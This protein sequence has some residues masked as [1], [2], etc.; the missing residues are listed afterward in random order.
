MTKKTCSDK[1]LMTVKFY[2]TLASS[3]LQMSVN[4]NILSQSVV[5]PYFL[6][7]NIGFQLTLQMSVNVKI[8][9][10]SV[11]L[12]YFLVCNIGFQLTLQMS[13]NVKILSQCCFTIFPS[14]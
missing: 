1:S 12:P 4:V 7:C 14:L 8:L 2:V 11:V 6:V 13:V 10:Q 3:S 5:L 9:S